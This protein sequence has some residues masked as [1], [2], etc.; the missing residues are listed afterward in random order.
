MNPRAVG[1]FLFVSLVAFVVV[2]VIVVVR[3]ARVARRQRPTSPS[4]SLAVKLDPLRLFLAIV[5]PPLA[6]YYA[7]ELGEGPFAVAWLLAL[8]VYAVG[9]AMA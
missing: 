3:V 7:W 4:T 9:V 1:I 6:P 5:L 8:S 2:H